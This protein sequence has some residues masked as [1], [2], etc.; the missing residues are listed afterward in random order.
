MRVSMH[1][2]NPAI[3]RWAGDRACLFRFHCHSDPK[4][5]HFVCTKKIA[6]LFLSLSMS[7]RS[8]RRLFMFSSGIRWAAL[9]SPPVSIHD[10]SVVRIFTRTLPFYLRSRFGSADPRFCLCILLAMQLIRLLE[11]AC[12]QVT[13]GIASLELVTKGNRQWSNIFSDIRACVHEKPGYWGKMACVKSEWF[14]FVCL[15]RPSQHAFADTEVICLVARN[16]H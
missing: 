5:R 1:L 3:V 11:F 6:N 9:S 14:L 13:K 15:R 10:P 8:I 4:C 2:P 12:I 7:F 16:K